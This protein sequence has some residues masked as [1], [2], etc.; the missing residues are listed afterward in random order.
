[1]STFKYKSWIQCFHVKCAQKTWT[2]EWC[3]CILGYDGVKE[4]SW[5]PQAFLRHILLRMEWHASQQGEMLLPLNG[6]PLKD[7]T[8]EFLGKHPATF[9][10][11]SCSDSGPCELFS[12]SSCQISAFSVCFA[13]GVRFYL[14]FGV[15]WYQI[16]KLLLC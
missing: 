15:Y 14:S 11:P 3:S 13:W 16:Q 9:F 12:L 1:M 6:Q 8:S 7:W 2:M 5:T 10:M 4:L